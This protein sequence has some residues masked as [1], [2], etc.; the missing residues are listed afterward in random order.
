MLF[1]LVLCLHKPGYLLGT[2]C[3]LVYAESGMGTSKQ[4]KADHSAAEPMT[5]AATPACYFTDGR[6]RRDS[7]KTRRP[8]C[9]GPVLSD[10]YTVPRIAVQP[11]RI[12]E[13]QLKGSQA[14]FPSLPGHEFTSVRSVTVDVPRRHT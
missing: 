8:D 5:D 14:K 11:R 4:Q 3:T 9:V 13:H 1:A 12:S 7:Q 10:D 2:L 6:P